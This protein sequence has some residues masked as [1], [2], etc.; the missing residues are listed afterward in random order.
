L[1]KPLVEAEAVNDSLMQKLKDR[2]Q[3]LGEKYTRLSEDEKKSKV[4]LYRQQLLEFLADQ[5]KRLLTKELLAL[6]TEKYK[7]HLRDRVW[8][9]LNNLG[10]E[11]I[12]IIYM[13]L[14]VFEEITIKLILP[15]FILRFVQF[16]VRE[17][18]KENF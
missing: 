5:T 6:T 7:I 4:L 10:G 8:Q 3:S 17:R 12:F 15:S 9:K 16:K 14:E 11:L 2:I 18:K 13:K 1:V